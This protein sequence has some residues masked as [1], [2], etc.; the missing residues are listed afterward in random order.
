MTATKVSP[1]SK[2]KTTLRRVGNWLARLVEPSV[3]VTEPGTRRQVQLLSSFV[4][5]IVV[6]LFLSILST[7]PTAG[8]DRSITTLVV[9]SIVLLAAYFISRTV[10]YQWATILVVVIFSLAAFTTAI[11]DPSRASS[12]IYSYLPIAFLIAGS[13]L[14]IGLATFI[15][16]ADTT[17]IFLLPLVITGFSV[18][19]AGT[20]GGIMMTLGALILIF[21]VVR[22]LSERD[23]LAVL[24]ATNQELKELQG[25]LEE[26]VEERTAQLRASAEVGRV[27]ASILDT[28][29]LLQ[30]TVNLITERFG[31]YYA[32][33]F[34]PD[35]AGQYA[36]LRAGTGEAGRLM[37]ERHH[38]LEIGGASMVGAAIKTHEPKIARQVGADVIR[39]ANPLLA[40]TQS[41]VALPLVV[42][43]RVLGA[44]DVQAIQPDAFDENTATVLQ[45]MANQIAVALSNSA[46]FEQSQIAFQQAQRLFEAR[47]AIAEADNLQAMLEVLLTQAVPEADRG[48]IVLYGPKTPSGSWVYLEI[49]ASWARYADDPAVI[50]G[51]RY[52]PKQLPFIDNITLPRPL[53][54]ADAAQPGIDADT[55]GVVETLNVK[56][57]IGVGLVA[58]TVPLGVIFIAYREPRPTARADVQ[59]L[60]ALS[61]QIGSALYS[62]RLAQETQDTLKQLDQLNRRL[63]GE[64]WTQYART[65]S[66]SIRQTDAAPDLTLDE[67]SRSN[68]TYLNAPITLRNAVIGN[69][70]LEDPDRVWAPEDQVL[71]ETI[72]DELSIA[73][74]NTRLLEETERR[75]QRE[76]L[77]AEV[78]SR[79]FASNDLESIIQI[80]GQELGRVL[81][82]DRAEI[83]IDPNLTAAPLA[84]PAPSGGNGLSA[85]R[86]A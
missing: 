14:P 16:I 20:D 70:R 86:P 36:V 41:E 54:I 61:G 1:P 76:R 52:T 6:L 11:N 67:A 5:A 51:T 82:V 72:A 55:R 57:A 8:V 68:V 13:L 79:M 46:L 25:S 75:A 77:V 63:T 48:I 44:L 83:K 49:G 42:G 10:Y 58:G 73:V 71:L 84:E 80:A 4:L 74:E 17:A 85:A 21:S 30:Q 39:F 38:R 18:R 59:P 31:F 28:E 3:K 65:T 64:A 9:I 15:V 50:A 37:K 69:L 22:N 78:S 23:R 34:T 7:I 26:R 2:L 43:S 27:A 66:G 60:Q 35:P 47:A 19:E 33:I 40:E 12:A 45:S 29:Q 81:R 24:A 56:A 53:V 62:Q 32:A